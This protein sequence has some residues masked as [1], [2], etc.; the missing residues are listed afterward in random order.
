[1]EDIFGWLAVGF[2]GER[3]REI[4]CWWMLGAGCWVLG[5]REDEELKSW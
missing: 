2:G 3:G 4:G 5:N 1:M